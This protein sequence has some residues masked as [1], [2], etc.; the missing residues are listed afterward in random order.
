[1]KNL[2]SEGLGLKS[3]TTALRVKNCFFKWIQKILEYCSQ[4]HVHKCSV[5]WLVIRVG[6]C[7]E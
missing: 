1:M 5:F 6:L 2:I 4:E 3:E 7:M